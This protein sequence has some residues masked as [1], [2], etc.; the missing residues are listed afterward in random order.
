MQRLQ[1]DTFL[2]RIVDRS[3]LLTLTPSTSIAAAGLIWLITLAVTCYS[4]AAKPLERTVTTNY[5]VAAE[6]F[7]NQQPMYSEGQHGWLYPPQGAVLYSLFEA[8]PS[9]AAGEVLW[10]IVITSLFA[11]SLFR[12]GRIAMGSESPRFGGVT[13]LILTLS[14]IA[15]AAGC[16]RNGQMNLPLAALFILACCDLGQKQWWRATLWLCLALVVKPIALPMV[17]LAGA[18]FPA[19]WWRLP[20]GLFAVVLLPFINPNWTYVVEQYHAA[21]VKMKSA[22]EPGAGV[23]SDIVG[24]CQVFPFVGP[25][26]SVPLN[27]DPFILTAVRGVAAVVTLG[28]AFLAKRRFGIV[29]GSLYLLL[30][31]T[32]YLMLFNPRTEGNSYPMFVPMVGVM[33]AW[34]LLIDKKLKSA[35]ALLVAI[36]LFAAAHELY[37]HKLDS[38][39]IRPLCTLLICGVASVQIVRARPPASALFDKK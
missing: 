11:F 25:G 23:F 1:P 3:G 15:L 19:L 33:F 13:F 22:G 34:A 28:L 37:Q 17:M 36:I 35:A 4:V 9:V 24:M 26:K 20:I 8:I 2:E 14:S 27:V 39:W 18:L 12:L 10:R 30:L 29:Q 16:M 32:G 38:L 21:L 31:G 5:R 6:A 7:W